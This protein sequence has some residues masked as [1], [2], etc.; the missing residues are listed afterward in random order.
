MYLHQKDKAPIALDGLYDLLD[1]VGG[2]KGTVLFFYPKNLTQGCNT[3]SAQFGALHGD[4]VAHGF[5][6]AGIS[7]GDKFDKMLQKHDLPYPLVQDDGTLCADFGVWQAKQNFGKQYMGIVRQTFV[8]DSQGDIIHHF[9]KVKADGHAIQVL[10][11]IS[12]I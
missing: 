1:R 2:A 11:F 12:G 9:A 6:I 7:V 10:H 5:G 4:F 8:L 3:E